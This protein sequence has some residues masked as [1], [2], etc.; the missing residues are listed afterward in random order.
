MIRAFLSFLLSASSI[1]ANTVGDNDLLMSSQSLGETRLNATVEGKS[2]QI[3]GKKYTQGIGTHASSMIP[4]T[5]PAGSTQLSGACGIDDEI[6]GGSVQF[7]IMTGSEVLWKSEVMKSGMPARPFSVD[8]PAGTGKLYLLADK[9]ENHSNDHADWVD[10]HWEKGKAP[11]PTQNNIITTWNADGTRKSSILPFIEAQR[12]GM[13]P[14][15][16]EDQGPALRRAISA[17][18]QQPEG[19]KIVIPKGEYHFYPEGGL[20]MNYHVSNHDQPEF[21]HVCMPLSDLKNVTIEGNGSRFIFHGLTQPV[22]IMDS[23][24]V[25]IKNL[26]LDYERQHYTEGTVTAIDDDTTTIR[27]DE[28]TSPYKIENNRFVFIGEGWEKSLLSC[29]AFEKETGHIV[30]GTSD[31]SWNGHVEDLGNGLCKMKWNLKSK[32]IKPG[33]TL[34]LRNWDRPHPA[35][36]IYR[37]DKTN[38]INFAIHDSQGMGIL[39]QRSSDIF[40]S[41]GGVFIRKGSGRVYTSG[42]DATHFS[43]TRGSIVVKNALFE[44]MMDDAI[45]VHSTCLGIEEIVS[46]STI[47]CR[48]KHSQAVGFETFLP[49]EKLRFIAGPTLEP[50]KTVHVK[51]V[52]KLNTDEILITLSS[53]LPAEV[54]TGDAVENASWYPSVTF[55]GNTIRNNRAR[56]SLFTTPKKVIVSNNLFDHSSG[57]AILLAGDAQGWYESGACEE[58]IITKNKFINNLT[59]RFQFTN[60]I[61]S[62]SPEVRQ[63]DKQKEYYHRNVLITENEFDTFDVPLL[64]AIST[65]KLQF[66]NNIIRYNND[67]KGWNAKP[68]EFIR[69]ANI[70]ISGNKVTPAK[71]WTI[72]DC[73]L[74]NMSPDEVKMIDRENSAK[75]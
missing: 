38:F 71:T 18:R 4:L 41:G 13:T 54:K 66:T 16:R 2:F 26:A 56:G 52:R 48:Y 6:S 63:L 32:G 31:I 75:K 47:R 55:T 8:I 20:K 27:I 25:S 59:S 70:T 3:G 7:S 74:K 23:R 64:F 36:V 14:G 15:V 11:Q 10:L 60:A 12:F 1:Y 45:N 43:N 58:V 19:C 17:A 67:Y 44:G 53:P 62:I 5:V 9:V 21:H 72:E 51:S 40:M 28:K 57:S 69:C 61:I 35:C 65:D 22:L 29:I 30:E 49:G 39:A 24:Q 42:A 68:F 73:S 50:G 34:V 37:S 33:D 46:P